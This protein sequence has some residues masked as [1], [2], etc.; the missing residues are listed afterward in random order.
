LAAFRPK[1]R[2][3]NLAEQNERAP[4]G[5]STLSE[6]ASIRPRARP[7]GLVKVVSIDPSVIAA[8]TDQAV[9]ASVR[10]RSRPA[11][12]AS[13]VQEQQDRQAATPV[14]R[15]QVVAPT[16]PTTASVARNATQENVIKLRKINLIGLYGSSNDRRALVRLS[17]GRYKKVKVGDR[18]DG[19][20]VAAISDSELRYVKGGRTLVLKM[21]R[22]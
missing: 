13:K 5:G 16:I 15:N 9:L 18:I 3:N 14:P 1:S 4:L 22:G 19:G 6:I 11:N 21:P 17:S 8:A 20:R 2:P 7:E 12:F 10:P